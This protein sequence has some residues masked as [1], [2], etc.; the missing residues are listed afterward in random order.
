MVDQLET[1]TNVLLLYYCNNNVR[2][3]SPCSFGVKIQIGDAMAIFVGSSVEKMTTWFV[4]EDKRMRMINEMM[5]EFPS[6]QTTFC[7]VKLS[8]ILLLW[9]IAGMFVTT[10]YQMKWTGC[11]SGD[12]LDDNSQ[13]RERERVSIV[14]LV[15]YDGC[16]E[17][18]ET[19]KRSSGVMEIVVTTHIPRTESGYDTN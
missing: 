17:H 1:E 4:L 19:T 12:F 16:D 15:E 7:K 9:Y 18:R 8:L 6:R 13:L 3:S 10:T 5:F 14:C 2:R 11:A